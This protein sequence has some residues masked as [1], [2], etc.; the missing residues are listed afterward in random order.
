MSLRR[1]LLKNVTWY[2][3]ITKAEGKLLQ[4]AQFGMKAA[5][6][7]SIALYFKGNQILPSEHH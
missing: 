1:C 7:Y 5:M 6:S 4:S 3:T 2:T